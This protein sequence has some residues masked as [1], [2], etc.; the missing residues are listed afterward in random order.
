MTLPALNTKGFAVAIIDALSA[1]ICVLDQNGV[2]IAIN[3]AWRNFGVENAG[4]SGSSDIGIHYLKVCQSAKG[5]GSD[6]AGPFAVGVR[7]VLEGK[8]Q[9]FQL[10]YPCHSPTELRWY[11]GRV[12]PL[13]IEQGGAVVSHQNITERKLLEFDLARLA[14]TDPLTGAYNRRYFL[15][16]ANLEVARVK[17]FSGAASVVMI[18]ID[19]FKAVN[20]TYGHAMGDQALRSV[21][22]TC[23]QA[24][25]EIDV[26]ARFGGEEF[27]ILLPE[28]NVDGAWRVA[29]KLRALL[30][31]TPIE[32]GGRTIAVTAS[33][34]VAD[35]WPGDE[36]VDGAIA[37][38]DTALY[39]AKRSGRNCVKAF[40][41]V[42]RATGT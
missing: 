42:Q 12:T 15:E 24:L 32:H 31:E 34:G 20:D 5:P 13:D 11:M 35:V 38:A 27:V 1:H 33:F 36:T 7:S 19:R 4:D 28:T 16:K 8:A 2:I 41:A 18:D 22:Q 14:A 26:F 40:A 10:E 37:R 23:Q 25:R 3:R 9:S 30:S 17:R 6:E 21:A 39:E 29:E